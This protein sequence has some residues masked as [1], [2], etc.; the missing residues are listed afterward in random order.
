MPFI[1]KS[2]IVLRGKNDIWIYNALKFGSL[3][4]LT[5]LHLPEIANSWKWQV[6]PLRCGFYV[7]TD[8]SRVHTRLHLLYQNFT[9]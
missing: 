1:C 5:K 6:T 7:Q 3:L 2:Q 9:G 8:Q 4:N